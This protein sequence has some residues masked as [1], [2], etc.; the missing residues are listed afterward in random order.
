MLLGT[1]VT[2]WEVFVV[3]LLLGATLVLLARRRKCP[4]LEGE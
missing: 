1:N 2:L 4:D 3:G